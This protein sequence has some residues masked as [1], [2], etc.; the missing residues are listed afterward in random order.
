MAKRSRSSSLRFAIAQ[1]QSR[2]R[3]PVL[4]ALTVSTRT[5]CGLGHAF[6][7]ASATDSGARSVMQQM[8]EPDPERKPPSAPAWVP[9]WM[10]SSRKG[11]SGLRKG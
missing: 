7:M 10:T 4:S 9:A 11:M 3:R 5:C 6:R 2:T 1:G 8:V